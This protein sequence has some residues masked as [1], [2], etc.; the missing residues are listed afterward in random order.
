M[1]TL[2]S[3]PQ[4]RGVR[5]LW[6]INELQL[7]FE[8][9]VIDLYKGEHRQAE[10]TEVSPAQKVPVLRDG[11][12]TIAESAAIVNYL[13]QKTGRLVPEINTPERAQFEEVMFFVTNELE[14]ALWT[15]AKHKFAL[16]EKYRVPATIE[17]AKWEFQQAL[18]IFSKMLG[19]KPYVCGD[20]FTVADIIAGH[21]L[22]WAKGFKQVLEH[23]NVND[24]ASS[25]LSRPALAEAR[26]FEKAL[27]DNIRSDD[28]TQD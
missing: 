18:K 21:T 20:H 4:T 14:Q 25:V 13:A 8:Y 28:K 10:F 3:Y 12:L 9:E 19:N 6:A 15:Q 11:S 23:E 7:D 2:F 17:T 22:S 24:Y 27:L 1:I 5:V 16:P 26:A